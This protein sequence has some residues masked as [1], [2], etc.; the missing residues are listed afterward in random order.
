MAGHK[1][2]SA[3]FKRQAVELAKT[4]GKSHGEIERELGITAGLLSKWKQRLQSDGVEAF[5]GNGHLKDSDEE[6]RRLQRELEIVT[7]ERDILKKA[8]A[9]FSMESPR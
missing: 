4:S 1:K 8:L 3:E 2:Y 6:V 5:P 7:Q 9:I